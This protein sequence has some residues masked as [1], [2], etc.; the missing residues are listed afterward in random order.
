MNKLKYLT[1]LLSIPMRGTKT[2]CSGP[3]PWARG[4]TIK[5]SWSTFVY[6]NNK[7]GNILNV[8]N[9]SGTNE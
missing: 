8:S 7:V 6:E 4:D 9:D 5:K 1:G 2:D 3:C